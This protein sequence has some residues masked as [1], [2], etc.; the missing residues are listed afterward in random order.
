MQEWEPS[1]A[2]LPAASSAVTQGVQVEVQARY[3]PEESAPLERQFFFVYRVRI[4]NLGPEAVRLESRHWIVLD[5]RGREEH[6]RGPGV[7]GEQPRLEPGEAFEYTSFCPLRTPN[8]SMRGTYR[9]V[10]D[11]G[12]CF[13]A[14]VAGFSL[15]APQLLN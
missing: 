6:A 3:V 8:G 14:T 9:M 1:C 5:G 2:G 10:R 4:S 7:V 15:L 11:D 13:D 12:S